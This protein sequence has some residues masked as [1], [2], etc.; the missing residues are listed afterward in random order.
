MKK[1]ELMVTE[2]EYDALVG[3]KKGKTWAELFLTGLGLDFED[4][5]VG[6]PPSSTV[7]LDVS[8]NTFGNPLS[9]R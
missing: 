7:A 2:D 8:P 1:I 5:Q 9:R 6:R 3:L 4:R